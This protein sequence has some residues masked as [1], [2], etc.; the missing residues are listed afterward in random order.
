MYSVLQN[1]PKMSFSFNTF[2]YLINSNLNF[3]I[4]KRL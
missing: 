4:I 3:Q 2:P 1:K